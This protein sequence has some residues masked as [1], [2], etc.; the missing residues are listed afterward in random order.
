MHLSVDSVDGVVGIATPDVHNR[1]IAAERRRRL[2]RFTGCK[3]P[4]L[5]AGRRVDRVE[6]VVPTPNAHHRTVAAERRRRPH[7]TTGC[8]APD[9]AAGQ[10]VNR[11]EA[12]VKTS[13]V[14]YL[15]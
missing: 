15:A 11:V 6:A 8:K 4:D 9:L 14:H 2:H 12:L 7:P 5:A 10:R 1:A 13:D 3:T